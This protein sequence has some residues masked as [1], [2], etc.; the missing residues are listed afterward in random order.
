MFCNDPCC[1][2]KSTPVNVTSSICLLKI[3]VFFASN[4]ILSFPVNSSNTFLHS[5][6]NAPSSI[7]IP[8]FVAYLNHEFF[9]RL[10]SAS[11]YKAIS[12]GF[13]SVKSMISGV[14]APAAAL[15]NAFLDNFSFSAL[16]AFP[17]LVPPLTYVI[18]S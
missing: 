14:Y 1:V 13:P 11:G 18:S 16:N 12:D 4:T 6:L 3:F 8:A 2:T 15:K 10:F 7:A 9:L 5:G 17:K